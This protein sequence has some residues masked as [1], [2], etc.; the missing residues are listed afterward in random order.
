MFF[1]RMK[2]M[3]LRA[4]HRAIFEQLYEDGERRI[5]TLASRSHLSERTVYRYIAKLEAGASLNPKQRRRGA[6]KFT[7]QVRRSMGQLNAKNP[8][9]SDRR[10]AEELNQRF[11]GH[12]STSGVNKHFRKMGN[13]HRAAKERQLRPEN[14]QMRL[15]YSR[16]NIL[17]DWRR[18][19]SYDES[20]FNL[21]KRSHR[22]RSNNR[23]SYRLARAPLTNSQESVSV[24]V[25]MAISRTTKSALCFLPKNWRV[26]QL[27]DVWENELLPSINWDPTHFHCRAFIMDN[28]GRHHSH[29]L[30]V[31]A[32][33]HRLDRI[34]Y[35]PANSPDLNP[36]ENLWHTMKNFVHE[37]APT[38]EPELKQAISDAYNSIQ[39]TELRHLFDSLPARMQQCIDANGNRIPY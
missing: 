35:L 9:L 4:R 32:S 28:D 24:S 5:S 30:H 22:V 34:G 8:E 18:I 2:G 21:W 36:I 1:V 26:Q 33:L 37:R 11:P 27:A 19:W 25:C 6:Y 15:V 12:F 29:V 14:K 7:P 3:S 39:V 31:T 38:N 16:N 13:R 10:I 20:S 17:T 23:T